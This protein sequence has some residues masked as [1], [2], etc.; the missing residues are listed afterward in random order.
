MKDHFLFLGNAQCLNCERWVVERMVKAT[1]RELT[2]ETGSVRMKSFSLEK[3]GWPQAGSVSYDQ[4][5]NGEGMGT[6]AMNLTSY[7]DSDMESVPGLRWG[8]DLGPV[9]EDTELKGK[10]DNIV[11]EYHR[12]GTRCGRYIMAR[13]GGWGG[14]RVVGSRWRV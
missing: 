12:G 11:K 13:Q 10:L 1:K 7:V 9:V 5:T 3:H 2:D 8:A 4:W 6:M 14:W